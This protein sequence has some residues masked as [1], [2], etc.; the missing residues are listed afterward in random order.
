METSNPFNEAPPGPPKKP[1]PSYLRNSQ[2]Y[3]AASEPEPSNQAP[4]ALPPKPAPSQAPPPL[5][6]KPAN[7]APPVPKKD[8]AVTA[9]MLDRRERDL[10]E[11]ERQL[12]ARE[13]RARQ[14]EEDAEKAANP[15]PAGKPKP[16]MVV[17]SLPPSVGTSGKSVLSPVSKSPIQLKPPSAGKS[18]LS[19]FSVPPPALQWFRRSPSGSR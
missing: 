9:D 7:V 3:A 16:V 5:P 4:P 10:D 13:A 12:I 15:R 18:P 6:P 14:L 2:Q 11:R 8:Y 1:L 17:A 19:S